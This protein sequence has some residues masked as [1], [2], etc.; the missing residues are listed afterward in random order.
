MPAAAGIRTD[1]TLLTP[2]DREIVF[3]LSQ[4]IRVAD[5]CQLART[6]WEDT[7]LGRNCAYRRIGRL[8]QTGVLESFT[9]RAHP[10]LPLKEPIWS[11]KPREARPPVGV[12]SYRARVRWDKPL[13]SMTVYVASQRTARLYAGCGGRLSHPLQ[14]THDLHVSAIYLRLLKHSPAEAAGWVS[15]NVLAPLRRRQKLPDAE[16]HDGNGRVLKVIEFGG[17]Y[18]PERVRLIHE[19][20][21]RRQVPY[22]LW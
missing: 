19:D 21:E 8:V 14:V 7:P 2:I 6:W 13:Q 4:R 18:P 10:E 17:S 5:I 12:V 20:C 1:R 16:I 3:T 15:E 9:L 11:W 22:E